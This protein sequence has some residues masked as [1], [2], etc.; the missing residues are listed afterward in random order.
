MPVLAQRSGSDQRSRVPLRPPRILQ[1]ERRLASGEPKPRP[2][3]G[4]LAAQALDPLL[5]APRKHRARRAP[6]RPLGQLQRPPKLA[7]RPPPGRL[8]RL[9]TEEQQVDRR[10]RRQP[11]HITPAR[12]RQPDNR[13]QTGL[14]QSSAQPDDNVAQ[15]RAPR[16]RQSRTPDRVSQ[17]LARHDRSLLQSQPC[18]RQL[19]PPTEQPYVEHRKGGRHPHP[20]QQR[21]RH[22]PATTIRATR[23]AQWPQS[24]GSTRR[25]EAPRAESASPPR[26]APPT[27]RVALSKKR[28]RSRF[29]DP[30][31]KSSS[32]KRWRRCQTG[33][34]HARY[35][36]AFH[37]S[38]SHMRETHVRGASTHLPHTLAHDPRRTPA[39][40]DRPL[41]Q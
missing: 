3:P 22:R 30:L 1:R 28:W 6:Q 27:S 18:H 7:R 20:A 10:A 32:A 24:Y 35:S 2:Q 5:L 33:F 9:L 17:S 36:A 13:V 14:H 12:G 37:A 39:A 19:G 41:A 34:A 40:T 26:S 8:L 23:H 25:A 16:R 38:P 21:H 31:P 29:V 15:R 4:D 11:Q